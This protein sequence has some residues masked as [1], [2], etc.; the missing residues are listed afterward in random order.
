M[1]LLFRFA[2]N[3]R[4]MMESVEVKMQKAPCS[5]SL[6]SSPQC[7]RCRYWRHDL[8]QDAQVL[9]MRQEI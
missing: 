1:A 4:R 2:R 8:R 9:R 7:K 3:E 5:P 6:P